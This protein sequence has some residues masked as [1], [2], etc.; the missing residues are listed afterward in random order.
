MCGGAIPSRYS[1]KCRAFRQRT[2]RVSRRALDTWSGIFNRETVEF[3]PRVCSCACLAKAVKRMLG[4]CPSSEE[5]E[6]MAFQSIKKLQPDSCPCMEPALLEGIRK[7]FSSRG[8]PL[9][10]G[11]LEFVRRRTRAMFPKA[12]DSSYFKF[13]ELL[14][15]PISACEGSSR[16]HGGI[17]GTGM[18]HAEVLEALYGRLDFDPSEFEASL[19]LPKGVTCQALVVQSAGKPRPLSKFKAESLL[20]K[21]LHKTIYSSLSKKKW[22]LRGGITDEKLQRAGFH[23]EKGCLVSGDYSSATDNLPI[24]VVE[25]ILDTMQKTACFVPPAIFKFA[26]KILRPLMWCFE[27]TLEIDWEV[28]VVRGQ[29]MG[30]L[31]SFPMLCLQNRLGLEWACFAE[32]REVPPCLINGDDILY[33]VPD[34]SFV[35]RWMRVV[36][37]LGLEVEPTKTSTSVNFG[38]LNST[39]LRW[40]R[41]QLLSVVHTLRFGQ[42][43][44][45][46]NPTSLSQSFFSF[47]GKQGALPAG[48]RWRSAHA[49]FSW[50]AVE[51]RDRSG[52]GYFPD[53]LGFRGRLAFRLCEKFGLFRG[54][55]PRDQI[56]D[57]PQG[58]IQHD[59]ILPA[60]QCTQVPRG[61]YGEEFGME[62][63]RATAS[64]KWG[65]DYKTVK[66][67]QV[68]WAL[69]L[70]CPARWR[71]V[72]ESLDDAK[73]RLRSSNRIAFR[74]TR[75]MPRAVWRRRFSRPWER[76]EIWPV[77]DVALLEQ[78]HDYQA[79][80]SYTSVE[81]EMILLKVRDK[82]KGT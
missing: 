18:D 11:Y 67:G 30:S 40:N 51:M 74:L 63:A 64:W 35:S 58:H 60:D 55:D 22:L 44:R 75:E 3:D 19:D 10:S 24:E 37:N 65:V 49:F 26:Q 66:E 70:A 52:C 62:V 61:D 46:E 13:C 77:F 25:V 12:W 14:S 29:M 80:P 36:G 31:L 20:L 39:L 41:D 43:R 45:S 69:S 23:K 79:L 32:G 50:H 59:V 1:K 33:Q 68:R 27:P 6:V 9:P 82:E 16:Q 48:V 57:P 76:K 34:E 71:A 42:L 38:T 53:E 21:P 17:L 56:R 28:Q 78:L 15:P 72:P 47:V 73:F 54:R 7:K 5:E 2:L 81:D 4:A 8:P